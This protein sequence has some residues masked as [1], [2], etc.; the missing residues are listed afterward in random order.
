MKV[1]TTNEKGIRRTDWDDFTIADHRNRAGRWEY[2]LY[3]AAGASHDGGA[4]FR[5]GLLEDR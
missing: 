2:R 3:N 1:T 4:W 5:E